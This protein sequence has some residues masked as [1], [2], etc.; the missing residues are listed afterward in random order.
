MKTI[1]QK[2]AIC[3]ECRVWY[4]DL[5][6]KSKDRLIVWIKT[7]CKNCCETGRQPIPFSEL[8]IED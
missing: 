3:Y 6:R 7:G 4:T 5:S 8:G 1:M 2:K